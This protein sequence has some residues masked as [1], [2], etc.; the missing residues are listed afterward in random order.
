MRH[1]KNF[2]DQAP[3]VSVPRCKTKINFDFVKEPHTSLSRVSISCISVSSL[4]FIISGSTSLNSAD[5]MAFE[6]LTCTHNKGA[7]FQSIMLN[8]KPS[9]E[10]G[11]WRACAVLNKLIV[12]YHLSSVST[13]VPMTAEVLPTM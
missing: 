12:S 5:R 1:V 10:P 6:A 11:C 2:R 7:P 3:E 4:N 8:Q 9:E 13:S